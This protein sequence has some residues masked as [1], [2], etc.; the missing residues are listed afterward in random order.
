MAT[1]RIRIRNHDNHKDVCFTILQERSKW[2]IK[3]DKLV[4]FKEENFPPLQWTLDFITQLH[5][6]VDDITR[7]VCTRK[8]K[9]YLK[10]L[11]QKFVFYQ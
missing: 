1:L 5:P 6:S 10:D 9:K 4:I 8:I 7:I 3:S 11:Q 2:T